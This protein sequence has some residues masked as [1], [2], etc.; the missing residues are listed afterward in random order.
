MRPIEPASTRTQI[1]S[2]LFTRLS[3]AAGY[4]VRIYP[5]EPGEG[6]LSL[7][8]TPVVVGRD[9]ACDLVLQDLDVSRRHACI[10]VAGGAYVIRDLDSLN[11]V[12]VNDRRVTETELRSGDR[13]ALGKVVLKFLRGHDVE[14]QYHETIYAMMV[15]D[16]LTG[17]PNRRH[18]A[19]ALARDLARS[20]RHARPLALV[21]F[22]IDHFKRV[23]DTHGHLAGDAVLREIAAR[24]RA[25]IRADEVL[26][27]WGGEE[28]AVLLP[29]SDAAQAA[30]F[31]ERLRRLVA[32]A[33]VS[34]GDRTIPVTISLGVGV[35][36]GEAITADDLVRRADEKLYAAKDAGRNRVMA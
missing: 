28:F 8:A 27:R 13:I 24:V 18:F 34:A 19:D 20:Q 32:D 33:P 23:N 35:T 29:E 7:P 15:T 26:A 22:D 5:V 31:A 17:I 21:L 2:T 6:V 16:G 10:E 11:G 12:V 14:T 1:V 30:E 36:Q 9:D 25:T 4:L 3:G